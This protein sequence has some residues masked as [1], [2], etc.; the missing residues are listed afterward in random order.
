MLCRISHADV[1]ERVE[2]GEANLLAGR[3]T[4][5][6]CLSRRLLRVK[7]SVRWTEI[8][9]ATVLDVSIS[10]IARF[11]TV[12]KPMRNMVAYGCQF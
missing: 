2:A 7:I 10:A 8:T 9:F 1:L 5:Q 11:I 6:S 12:T 3:S 4:P